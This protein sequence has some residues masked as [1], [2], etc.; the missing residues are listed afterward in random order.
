MLL[1]PNA[2]EAALWISRIILGM[3]SANGWR[4]YIVTSS[5]IGWAHTQNDPWYM[6]KGTQWNYYELIKTTTKPNMTKLLAYLMEYKVHVG[7]P[8]IYICMRAAKWI[9]SVPEP[10]RQTGYQVTKRS[11]QHF[12]SPSWHIGTYKRTFWWTLRKRQSIFSMQ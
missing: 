10:F 6:G 8:S 3:S 7:D 2:N 4:R 1:K 12:L 11:A 9:G 5:P